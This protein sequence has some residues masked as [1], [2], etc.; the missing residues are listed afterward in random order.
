ML[1]I[2]FILAILVLC[3]LWLCLYLLKKLR[4]VHFQKRSLSTKYG[5]TS[6]QFMPFLRQYPYDAGNFRFI[7]TPIDGV[8]FENDKIV[9][10][11]FKT[12]TSQLS[13]K[14]KKIKEQ[15]AAKK[16]IFEEFRI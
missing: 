11:E 9:F 3:L 16:I 1:K 12:S 14:Q 13:E 7:G 5:K 15:I 4:Q 2:I 10:V 8:Q 6:E